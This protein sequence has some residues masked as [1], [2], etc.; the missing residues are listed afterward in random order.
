METC[1]RCYKPTNVTIMSMFNQDIICMGCKDA[2]RE[3]PDYKK[4]QEIERNAVQE[5]VK[6]FKGIGK[7]TDL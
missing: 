6:N 2:E 1:A 7:P 3:H 4:A 5:G